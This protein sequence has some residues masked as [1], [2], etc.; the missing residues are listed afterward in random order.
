[1]VVRA[2]AMAA[3]A[4]EHFLNIFKAA[5]ATAP[6]CG[7]IAQLLSDYIP[8][9]RLRRLETFARQ[10]AEDMNRLQ[11]KIRTENLLTDDFAFMFE[12]CFRGAAENYQK[13]KL[14]AYRGILVN[15]AIGGGASSDEREYFANLLAK[16]TPLHIRILGVLRNPVPYLR[17]AGISEDQVPEGRISDVLAKAFP[18]TPFV[19]VRAAY[20]DVYQMDLV[21]TPND[22]LYI[23]GMT[24]S[25]ALEFT[26]KLSDLG[27]R[28]I[29]F[30]TLPA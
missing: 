22:N 17:M 11:D 10:T 12:K 28:F 1:M 7:G 3:S 23:G 8:S 29:E 24:R 20:V 25:N 30:C 2:K 19:A 26:T 14:D 18:S 27:Q 5:L 13:E 9:A 21:T 15:S 6:F 16:L 4:A